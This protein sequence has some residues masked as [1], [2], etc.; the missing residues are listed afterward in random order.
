MKIGFSITFFALLLC[1]SISAQNLATD[2]LSFLGRAFDSRWSPG[3]YKIETD[4]FI[5]SNSVNSKMFSDVFFRSSFSQEAKDR[6]LD[7]TLKR[8]NIYGHLINLAE[9][10]ISNELGVFIKQKSM[11]GFSADKDMTALL[12]WGNAS[13]EDQNVTTENLR[14]TQVNTIT[15]GAS[16]KLSPID[17]W[18]IKGWYGVSLITNLNEIQAARVELYTAKGGDYL[19][20][21]LKNFSMSEQGNGVRGAGLEV[22]LE[23]DYQLNE[24][25]SIGLKAL[26]F[27]FNVLINNTYL[28]LD[29][30][31]RFQGFSYNLSSN[32]L[33]IAKH[34]DS[35]YNGVLENGRSQKKVMI[36]P[37]RLQL[38]WNRV[39]NEK[40]SLSIGLQSV[41]LGN[42]GVSGHLSYK[43]T[44]SNKFTV[45]SGLSYGNFT[46]LVWIE[47]LE[48]RI[49]KG[50]SIFGKLRN[51]NAII[52]PKSAKGSGINLGIA[53]NL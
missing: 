31:F 22:G 19:D 24:S 27:N 48:Y 41:D 8:V 39:L 1:Q 13:F 49:N 28:N 3:T 25:N 12:L 7:G 4:A 30:S 38:V 26:D 53:K 14:V 29:S 51:L 50:L 32:A 33:P 11:V 6:F 35:T 42:Y 15:L 46:G 36:L 9:F 43:Y 52:T 44:F 47:S 45:Q 2:S 37:T 23:I 20:V 34:L 21:S 5:G 40:S 16:H 17:K 18:F 10:K